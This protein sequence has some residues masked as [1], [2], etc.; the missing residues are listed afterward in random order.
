M[1]HLT[2]LAALVPLVFPSTTAAQIPVDSLVTGERVRFELTGPVDDLPVD[3]EAT[4]ETLTRSGL[5]VSDLEGFKADSTVE[6]PS[7]VVR[8]SEAARGTGDW[9]AGGAVIGG[10]SFCGVLLAFDD[11][12]G[13]DNLGALNCALGLVVGGTLGF[14]VGKEITNEQWT[15]VM[16]N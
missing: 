4:F 6:L 2:R 12:D 7:S 15:N 5:L 9:R 11:N 8:H 3:G 16:F 1:R 10:L 14:L 13:D